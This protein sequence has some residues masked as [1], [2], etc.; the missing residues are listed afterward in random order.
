MLLHRLDHFGSIYW[1]ERRW[2]GVMEK[3]TVLPAWKWKCGFLN[4][5]CLPLCWFA[6]RC[7][8]LCVRWSM[9]LRHTC[10]YGAHHLPLLCALFEA[11]IHRLRFSLL[12]Q[13]LGTSGGVVSKGGAAVY[14]FA[15]IIAERLGGKYCSVKVASSEQLKVGGWA[16]TNSWTVT[17]ELLTWL[18]C[19][20]L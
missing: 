17:V 2:G 19:W 13:V 9:K 4:D 20:V 5:L 14:V 18:N 15:W 11:L 6:S 8:C 3:Y 7:V 12:W 16:V 1:E 10:L